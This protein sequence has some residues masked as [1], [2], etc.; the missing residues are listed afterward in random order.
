MRNYCFE[1]VKSSRG[2]PVYM[3]ET[4]NEGSDD[5]AE[6]FVNYMPGMPRLSREPGRVERVIGNLI[7]RRRVGSLRVVGRR[8]D[9]K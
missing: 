2:L 6:E 8:R 1:I 7:G 9:D 5:T 3:T 4:S